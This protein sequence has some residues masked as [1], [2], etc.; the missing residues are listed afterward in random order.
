MQAFGGGLAIVVG[1]YV[2]NSK[3][4]R[5]LLFATIT[6][7]TTVR[8]TRITLNQ[9][10][11]ANCSAISFTGGS[12]SSSVGSSS[13]YGGAFALLHSPQL[14]EFVA[15]SLLPPRALT[16]TGNNVIVHILN[17]N[18][19]ECSVLTNS[20]SVRPG[21]A[22]GGGGAVYANSVALSNFSVSNS[23]FSSSSVTVACGATGVP[24]NSSG[25]ALAVEIPGSSYSVV[26]ISFCRFVNCTAR[27]ANISNL[28]VRGGAVAVSRVVSVSVTASIFINCS[29]TDA[30][31]SNQ[32]SSAAVSGGSGMSVVLA[33]NAYI[34]QCLF[35]AGGGQDSSGTSTG[36]F[37]IASNSSRTN[38]SI[39]RTSMLSPAVALNVQ[40]VSDDESQSVECPQSGP[41][42]SLTNSNISQLASQSQADFNATGSSLI[43]LQSSVLTLFIGS[44][45]QCALPQFAAFKKRYPDSSKPVVYSCN[46]CSPFQISLSANAVLLEQL[47]NATD[48]D[49]C[50]HVSNQNSCPFGVTDCATFVTVS[51]GFWTTFSNLTSNNLTEVIRCPPGYCGCG[52]SSTCPL[53]PL[54]SIDRRPDPLCSSNRSGYLCG[55]CPSNFTQSIDSK[56]CISNDV[57]TQ[58]LWWVWLLSILGF[59]LYSLYIVVSCARHSGGAISCVLFY[60]QMSSFASFDDSNTS[61]VILEYSQIRSIFAMYSGACYAPDFS[62]YNAT[63]V[64]LIGPL[65]VLVFTVVWTWI[66]QTLQ[67]KLQQRNI[68]IRV[69]FSGTLIVTVMFVFSSVATV[70]FTLLQCTSYASGGVVFIDGTVPCT[71]D[72]WKVLIFV[73]VLL[74]MFPVAYAVA[75][76]QNRLPENARAAV[77]HAYTTSAFYWGAVTLGFRFLISVTEFLKVEFP[78]VLSFVR[79]FLSAF[80]LVLLV[81]LRPYVQPYT[82]WVDV[83]C[84]VCLIAQFGLQT[85]AATRDFLGVPASPKQAV[86]FQAISTLSTMFRSPAYCMHHTCVAPASVALVTS[87]RRY[88]PVAVF[89]VAWLRTKLSFANIFKVVGRNGRHIANLAQRAKLRIFRM[90]DGHYDDNELKRAILN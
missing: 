29:L 27:G 11:F 18:F 75:L 56:T 80:M 39:S 3:G 60:F 74:C 68:Q 43:S 12:S 20:T 1:P 66:L 25:G 53:T 67:P 69:S 79:L 8:N 28:A 49:R 46:P 84:Y 88:L 47:L 6:G 10:W 15:G 2:F 78:N 19:F 36:V 7:I 52:N 21:T 83:V 37:I 48:V 58:N 90:R 64:K 38:L 76:R 62:A 87:C 55:G 13:V 23:N 57:C 86:F 54:L 50:I 70:V 34:D 31:I 72:R 16:M 82:F 33:R 26:D 14:S 41:S 22:N 17:S 85:M 51:S 45:M 32:F 73:V 42:V 63:A 81:N 89:A 65:F 30:A 5:G 71:D 40:C 35:D 24:S 4:P 9:T 61:N 44:R 59:A 77:C